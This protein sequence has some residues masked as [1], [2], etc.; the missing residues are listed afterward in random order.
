[1]DIEYLL[2]LQKIRESLGVF[3]DT[4][5][6]G[7]ST[8]ASA[9]GALL[10]GAVFYWSINKKLGAKIALNLSVGCFL[11]Q[12]L[13]SIFCIYRP[14]VIDRRIHP[15]ME[16]IKGAAGYSFPSGHSQNAINVYGALALNSKKK[17][18]K[19]LLAFLVI[20]IAF[21]RNFLGVHTPQDVIVG[22][23]VGYI[24]ILII[25]KA[26]DLADAKERNSLIFFFISLV[27]VVISM[28]YMNQKTY[29]ID[30]FEGS[31]IIDPVE[32]I[33]K[34]FEIGGMTIGVILGW[35]LERRYVD[36]STDIRLKTRILRVIL[37][38]AVIVGINYLTKPLSEILGIRIGSFLNTF[39]VVF[40]V[41]FLWPFIFTKIEKLNNKSLLKRIGTMFICIAPFLIVGTLYDLDITYKLSAIKYIDGVYVFKIRPISRIIELFSEWPTAIL[42]AVLMYIIKENINYKIK[43]T[44][45]VFLIDAFYI[46][47]TVAGGM[48]EWCSCF[49]DILG[50]GKLNLKYY[51]LAFILTLIMFLIAL[52]FF[53]KIKRETIEK[54]YKQSLLI[55]CAGVI[56]FVIF[57]FIKIVWGR[58]RLHD[59]I[60]L[61]SLDG[62][63]PWYKPNFLSGGMSFP[64]G[65]A[66]KACVLYLLIIC[67]EGEEKTK[68]RN[69]IKAGVS[70]WLI[71]VCMN[72]LFTASHYLTDIVVGV[73]LSLLAIFIS[74]EIWEYLKTHNPCLDLLGKYLQKNIM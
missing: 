41:S 42:F 5:F 1:M 21:S 32:R 66:A 27:L 39:L 48:R 49:S 69:R 71:V 55:F 47:L 6:V 30:Y 19:I 8:L 4:L 70:I 3:G 37:G 33:G 25:D 7:I 58:I 20:L 53:K 51:A 17:L 43:E 35:V 61:G 9:M 73:G 40:F 64:S 28:I 63:T 13:K 72:R 65:H 56:I 23:L 10:V 11:S 14:W 60:A 29:P 38:I 18:T 74:L 15:S 34:C 50:D 31:I 62:F 67:F 24:S 12:I 57:G 26:V 2:F 36:F 59:L 16:A 68:Q 54:Y 44:R 52:H 45:K 46:A 22:L